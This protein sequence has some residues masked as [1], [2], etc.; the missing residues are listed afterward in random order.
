MTLLNKQQIIDDL[1]NGPVIVVFTKADGTERIMP[2]T[3]DP[4]YILFKTG[5]V[6]PSCSSRN[7]S[8]SQVVAVYDL[9][10]R[11]WRSFRWDSVI[12]TK[13]V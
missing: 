6:A 12:Y 2:C 3:I 10:T 13:K 1:A 11:D 7:F 8:H 4:T 9:E 5:Q